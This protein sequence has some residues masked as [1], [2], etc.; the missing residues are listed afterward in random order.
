MNPLFAVFGALKIVVPKHVQEG[1][2]A[3]TMYGLAMERYPQMAANIDNEVLIAE[4]EFWVVLW[5][6]KEGK[7][8]VRHED[9]RKCLSKTS[10]CDWHG[11][12]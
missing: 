10:A 4:A 6:G 11:E 2:T 8:N 9:G 7:S 1:L 3:S 5:R 12:A